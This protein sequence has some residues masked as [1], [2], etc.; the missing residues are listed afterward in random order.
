MHKFCAMKDPKVSPYMPEGVQTLFDVAR[1]GE[2]F[3][4][5]D[6][7]PG[8]KFDVPFLIDAFGCTPIDLALGVSSRISDEEVGKSD[9]NFIDT[10]LT[11]VYL[12]NLKDQPFLNFG[13]LIIRSIELCILSEVQGLGEFLDSRLKKVICMPSKVQY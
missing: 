12:K 5:K 1:S 2:V 3:G 10:E 7:E 4:D 13:N 11:S 8:L 9:N 6:F